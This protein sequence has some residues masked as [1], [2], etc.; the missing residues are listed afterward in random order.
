MSETRANLSKMNKSDWSTNIFTQN[1]FHKVSTAWSA[2]GNLPNR[3]RMNDL[4]TEMY[5]FLDSRFGVT[6]AQTAI[7]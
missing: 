5:R 1:A 2:C 3:S 4:S 7:R 6:L